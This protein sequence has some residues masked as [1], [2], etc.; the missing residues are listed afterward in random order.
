M[1][2]PLPP[3]LPA[4]LHHLRGASGRLAVYAGGLG[5]PV[6]L[7]HSVNAL[8]SAAEIRPLFEA[9]RQDHSV[10]A[11]D[12]PGYGLSDRLPR[13]Y[14]VADMCAAILLVAQWVA[15]R[16][17]GQPLQAVGVSLSCEFV[18]RVAQQSPD[19]LAALT[20]VSPTGFRGGK[21]LRKPEG[22]TFFMAGFDQFLR[23]PGPG[24]GRFLFRQLS[25]P[26][27][28]RY[29]LRRTWGGQQIDE[30][31]WA[32]AVRTAHVP[33]AEQAPLSFLSG[34]LFS[35]DM[36]NVYESLR[37]PVW[38]VHGTRGDFT[39]YRAL[40]L[41]RHRPNW[42]VT[43]MQAGAMPY[44]EDIETFMAG[45]RAFEAAARKPLA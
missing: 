34:G 28:V 1:N 35:A 21:S 17:P 30:T 12:L 45:F 38:V 9:L 15:K 41:V 5:P 29:F 13:A 40:D 6:L 26:S 27:V 14:S 20:L 25:R 19:L 7:V 36:H 11:L 3:A 4:E 10:Y 42:Q 43:V 37:L 31:L 44:F 39:D 16:H 8:A 32:Y 23:R 22:S 33:N 2:T 18:A 24:W